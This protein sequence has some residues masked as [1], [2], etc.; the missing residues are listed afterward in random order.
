MA[1]VVLTNAFVS[2]NS[3]DLSDHVKSVTLTYGVDTP[4]DTAM[5]AT[6][7]TAKPGLKK[8]TAVVQFYQDHA[9]SKVN[10]TVY[11][12]IGSATL[13]PAVFKADSAAGTNNTYTLANAMVGG[14]YNP[15]AGSV[16][17]MLM[18]SVT[19]I[20]GSGFTLTKS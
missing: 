12:L 6:F 4:E 16:G 1:T 10:E 19:L 20:P 17:D 3:V 9:G 11:P 7:H 18:T 5:G 15:I 2:I 14:D 8:F 13:F